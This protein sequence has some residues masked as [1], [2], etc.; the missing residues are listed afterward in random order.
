MKISKEIC[1]KFLKAL[2]K[3]NYCLRN[4]EDV[5]FEHLN[6]EIRAYCERMGYCNK[7]MITKKDTLCFLTSQGEQLL[8]DLHLISDEF[9]AFSK[10]NVLIK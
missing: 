7:I 1:A 5:S 3:N 4:L 2:I 6:M 9:E 8:Q 10:S